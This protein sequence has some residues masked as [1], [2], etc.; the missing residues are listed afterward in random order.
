MSFVSWQYLFL[1]FSVVVLYWQLPVRAR[2]GLLWGAS[3]FFYGFWD[4]RFLALIFT[5]TTVDFFCALG[6]SGRRFT[7]GRVFVT[8]LLPAVWLALGTQFEFSSGKAAWSTA[9]AALVFPALFPWLYAAAF[10]LPEAGR[11]RRMLG[12]SIGI[13]LAVLGCFK[14]FGFFADSLVDLLG[15]AAINP[16][17]TLPTILL[18]VGISF[19]TFQSISYTVEVYRG[20]ATPTDRFPTFATYLSF[21]PQ[22][23]AGPIE[24][25]NTL[26]PQF[27]ERRTWLSEDLRRGLRLILVGWFKKVFVADNCAMLANYAFSADT[28]LNAPWAIIGTVAFA[29]Q[30]YGDFSGYTDIARGSARLLGF[31][32]S[33]N[34]RF[35][36]FSR[37]PSEF[38]QRWHITLSS[39]FRDYVYIPLGGNRT[40]NTVR[41][42]FLTMLLAGLW[43][44]ASWTF[45]I[46]GCYHGLLLI[47]YRQV[48][49]LRNLESVSSGRLKTVGAICLMSAFTLFGWAIFRASDFAAFT[50]WCGALGR[51]SG[52]EYVPWLPPAAWL[53]IHIAPLLILQASTWKSRDEAEFGHW[54][55]PLRVLTVI[56][57]FLLVMSSTR[58]DQEFLY[59]QF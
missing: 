49:P 41:N 56:L 14:Y 4:A 42:L 10:R 12:I 53:L 8:S 22:L 54:P 3:Y 37:G 45:V 20:N 28:E 55:L 33:A 44:G 46:W 48:A 34:F 39:W 17:W 59:F 38:W 58:V 43:H 47:A 23:V 24:R 7:P 11:R 9:G 1:L 52:G 57:L 18:P 6:V 32:L 30:I 51:W 13:N 5:T 26:L 40:A 2:I 29:F 16:G 27:L 50:Y 25:P 19:Y 31:H 35:P 15:L 36:Y 21:F